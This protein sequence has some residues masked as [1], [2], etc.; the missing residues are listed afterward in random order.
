MDI[1]ISINPENSSITKAGKH[2]PSRFSMSTIL[3]LKRIKNKNDVYGGKY[4]MK[5]FS[6]SLKKN[7][8]ETINFFKKKW[9][10]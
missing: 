1:K 3:S 2:I 4:C 7:A 6:E 9:S 5:K 8:M 10:Y